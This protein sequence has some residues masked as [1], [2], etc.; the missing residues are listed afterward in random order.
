MVV[1]GGRPV[2]RDSNTSFIPP[3]PWPQGINI[4]DLTTM[5]WA[6]EYDP[7]A[8]AYVTPGV[9]KEYYQSNSRYPVWSSADVESWFDPDSK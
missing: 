5:E 3:D 7:K 1:I 6:G 2:T 8:A 4:F 9:V